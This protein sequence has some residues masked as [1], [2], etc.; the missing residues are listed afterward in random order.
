MGLLRGALNVCKN[1]LQLV[2]FYSKQ[3]DKGSNPGRSG[4]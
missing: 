3:R 2:V 1:L 4:I